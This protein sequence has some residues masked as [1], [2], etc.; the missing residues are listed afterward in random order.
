MD[1]C[2]SSKGLTF[3]GMKKRERKLPLGGGP[4]RAPVYG[5]QHPSRA[6]KE[7]GGEE[8]VPNL[9]GEGKEWNGVGR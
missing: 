2:L 3:F 5:K 1:M 7:G 8:S 9:G 6:L 4:G